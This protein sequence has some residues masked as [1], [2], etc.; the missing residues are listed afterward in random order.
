MWGSVV[1]F[2]V[3]AA[4]LT[5]TPGIDTALVIRNTL[6]GGRAV[7][8]RT[9]LGI[10]CGLIVWG[11]L[12]ALGVT[13]VVT[14]SR[15]AFDA[16]RLAGAAYLIFLGVRTLL[17]TRG[18]DARDGGDR[19]GVADG[20]GRGR[21]AFRT[22]MLNNLLNPKV[23]VFYV[24]LL[25]QFVPAGTSVL[26]VSVLLASVHF[27]EGVLWLSLITLVV[28]RAARLMRRPAVR[29]GM[30]RVTGLVLL[31]FGARVALERV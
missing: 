15:V 7:G 1:G 12:S 25:P 10:C 27:V 31:G 28:H 21:A 8:L 18:G 13:A 26:G 11:L 30:E 14:A 6:Q 22:G 4:L 24:T 17:A 3:V 23:G 2:A 19:L 29:R 9:S 16:L 5:V 20:R